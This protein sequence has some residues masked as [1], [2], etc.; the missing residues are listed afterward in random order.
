MAYVTPTADLKLSFTP[1]TDG[2]LM[3]DFVQ[4]AHGDLQL[5]QGLARLLQDV[6]VAMMTP[7]GARPHDP[8]FGNALLGQIGRPMVSDINTL[9]AMA[10]DV[11]ASFIQRQQIAAAQGY[12]SLDEQVLEFTNLRIDV[13]GGPSIPGLP[14]LPPGFVAISFTI[15]SLAGTSTEANIPFFVTLNSTI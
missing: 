6:T 7:V 13:G 14:H 5:V 8:T 10:E 12:L 11:E 4:D 2:S 15:I 1:Q 9:F 3:I